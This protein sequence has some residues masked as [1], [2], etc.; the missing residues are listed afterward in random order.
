MDANKAVILFTHLGAPE[1][2]GLPGED[3]CKAQARGVLMRKG[4]SQ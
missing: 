4:N 1:F 2:L 3:D